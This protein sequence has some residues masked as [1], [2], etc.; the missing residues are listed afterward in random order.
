MVLVMAV[1][2]TP[3]GTG[4]ASQSHV[5]HGLPVV[6][7]ES[8]VLL[9]PVLLAFLETA[10]LGPASPHPQL[11]QNSSYC[12]E[13]LFSAQ[14]QA[15]VLST[16]SRVWSR[17]SFLEQFHAREGSDKKGPQPASVPVQS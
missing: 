1:P 16:G 3:V 2:M 7:P 4:Q 15:V 13:E 6:S 5:C 12:L 8:L 10:S 17:V 9:V 11:H 14:L